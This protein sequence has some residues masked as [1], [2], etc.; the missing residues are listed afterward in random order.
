MSAITREDVEMLW[1]R[2]DQEERDW[3]LANHTL[4]EF[5]KVYQALAAEDRV[6]VDELL[7]EWME[8]DN[9][10][11]QF[12][13]EGLARHFRIRSLLP[14][15]Q[16]QLMKISGAVDAPTVG[17]RKMLQELVARLDGEG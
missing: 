10:R 14:A 9:S 5:E 8:S 4:V 12:D 6:V 2:F 3:K 16:S 13:A 17:R 11:K 1:Q 15:V 7:A